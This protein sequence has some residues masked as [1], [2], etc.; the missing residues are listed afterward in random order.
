MDTLE[1][2]TPDAPGS[3]QRTSPMRRTVSQ[4]RIADELN[5]HVTLVSKVLNGRMGT[6]GVSPQLADRIRETA[7]AMGYRKNQNAAALRAGRPQ[8]VGAFI[9]RR[10]GSAGSGIIEDLVAG[11]AQGA[12]D[13]QQRQIISFYD[14]VEDFERVARTFHAASVD[15]L[16]IAGLPSAELAAQIEEIQKRVVR[17]VTVFNDDLCPGVA[18]ITMSDA[19]VVYLAAQHLVDR[20]RR[21]VLHIGCSPRRTEGY[22]RALREAGIEPDP[23]LIDI[24]HVEGELAYTREHGERAVRRAL[25]AAVAFDAICAQSDMQAIGAM[26]ALIR[27]GVQVPRD[28]MITGVDD[29]PLAQQAFIPLTSVNQCFERRG[30]LAVGLLNTQ[31]DGGARGPVVV[32]PLLVVRQSTAG[33]VSE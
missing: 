13:H 30:R 31:L 22:L 7:R 11:V 18:N 29:S 28:V 8:V 5:V 21:R 20:G 12:R 24:E 10:M 3:S 17:V 4:Q 15:G 19:Q 16:I 27:R 25:D 14:S 32:E 2:I 6:S 33:A 23:A 26:Y 1:N 9:D